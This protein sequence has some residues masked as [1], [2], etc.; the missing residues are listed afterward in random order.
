MHL[1]LLCTLK[2]QNVFTTVDKISYENYT[3]KT[4]SPPPR[5]KE[6]EREITREGDS[7]REREKTGCQGEN[8]F[9][10]AI[11]RMSSAIVNNRQCG[12]GYF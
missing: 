1:H 5:M 10:K 3:K 2:T 4:P 8:F 11:K 12:R 7:E 9:T 6:E